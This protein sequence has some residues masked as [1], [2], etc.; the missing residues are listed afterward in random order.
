[1]QLSKTFGKI[2]NYNK[3][4]LFKQSLSQTAVALCIRKITLKQLLQQYKLYFF[5]NFFVF[6]YV[7]HFLKSLSIHEIK[8]PC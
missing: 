6:Q 7:H 5:F 4:Q 1:M 2:P 3:T 8:M